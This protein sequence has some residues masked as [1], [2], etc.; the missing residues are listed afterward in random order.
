MVRYP[1]LPKVPL[2]RDPTLNA[3]QD[4]VRQMTTARGQEKHDP[5]ASFGILCERLGQ[6]SYAV[7]A[8]Q[9]VKAETGSVLL[10]IHSELAHLLWEVVV[11]ANEVDTNMA[12]AV[13]L[14]ERANK[15]RVW[16]ET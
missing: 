10:D 14:M 1:V 4:Y 15:H 7:R 12:D 16:F 6:L 3:L 13:R 8:F 2:A 5:Y 9:E 11:L